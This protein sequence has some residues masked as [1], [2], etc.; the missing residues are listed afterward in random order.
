MTMYST[1]ALYGEG[2][3]IGRAAG[4]AEGIEIGRAQARGQIVDGILQRA[5]AAEKAAMT[6]EKESMRRA[7]AAVA[8]W[9][10]GLSE[11]V[12]SGEL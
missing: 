5:V 4:K 10:R 12:L 3:D 7:N 8:V 9:L 2:Y 1:E 6:A 11:E